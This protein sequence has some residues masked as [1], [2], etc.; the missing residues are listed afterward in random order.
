V[1]T[2]KQFGDVQGVYLPVAL[3]VALIVVGLFAYAVVRYRVRAGHEA[4]R[5]TRERN[6]LEACI[7][8]AIAAIVVV[9]VVVT[10]DANARITDLRRHGRPAFRVD[11]TSFKWGWEFRYPSLPGVV[12]RS[13]ADGPAILH[14][15]AD[16]V[17]RFR[18]HTRDVVH[19]F[20]VPAVRFKQDAWP[21]TVRT[22]DLVFPPGDAISGR[23]AQFCGLEH[24]D[25]VFTVRAMSAPEL[26]AWA[27]RAVRPR[28]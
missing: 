15:P 13:G 7:A 28:A 24:S 18:L 4:P 3:A 5:P 1:Q 14:V 8:L 12:D 25:M 21:D 19:A 11:V 2:R 26:R 10:F 17:V 20:W 6:L 9:L 16:R 23:C 27:A 22:F